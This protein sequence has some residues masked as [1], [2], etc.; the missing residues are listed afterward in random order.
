M[1]ATPADLPYDLDAALA[2]YREHG[3][4]RLGKLASD[5]RLEAMRARIDAIMMGEVTYPGLF[6][7]KDTDSGKYEDLAYGKGFEGP[8][9]SYRKVEKLERDPIFLDWIANP[10]FEPLARTVYGGDVTLY[11]AL[12][13]NKAARTGGSN[14]PWHQDGGDFWGLD[15]EPGLQI[16]TALDDAPE[17]GGC[18][19]VVP[20]SHHAGLVTK[21]GGVVPDVAVAR[22]NP[23][24]RSILLPA[25]AG[26]VI[27]V[28]NHMWHRSARSETGKP[29]RA[30]TVCYLDARTE[31]RRK[32]REPRTFFKVFPIR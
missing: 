19:E 23:E 2:H 29:R 11:R 5:E 16:W 28:H 4:A 32:K 27:L 8:T 13:F 12:I 1:P 31:C 26:E 9:L 18:L 7:Q 17:N 10:I 21:L 15:R 20:K 30:L 24:A 22:E 25:V 3:Y 6:F 14:L